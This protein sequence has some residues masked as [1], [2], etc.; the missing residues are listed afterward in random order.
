MDYIK[1][2][3]VET[4]NSGHPSDR[5][6]FLAKCISAGSVLCMG[7]L[8][9]AALSV[10]PAE[11]KDLPQPGMSN[12]EIL[13]FTLGYSVPVLKKMQ[14]EIGNEKFIEL[15]K[16]SASANMAEAVSSMS[17]DITD[18]NMKNFGEFVGAFLS[19]PPF[20]GG[21]TYE[22]VENSEK[23]FEL[24]FTGCI[25]AKLYREMNAADIGYAVECYPSDAAGKA[26][27]PKAKASGGKNMM[28]GDE[29]CVER[30]EL[31]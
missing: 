11:I 1:N 8:G 4:K 24:K 30:W 29:Y 6:N 12:E 28:K 7:C 31:T 13:R 9:T 16:K 10:D 21:F 23:A 14:A 26:F 27:N 17:K 2:L 25:M 19:S 22:I 3:T 15:L 20:T 18:R 5:R